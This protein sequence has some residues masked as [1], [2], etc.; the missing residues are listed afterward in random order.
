MNFSIREAASDLMHDYAT[1]IDQDRLE[2]WLDL[3]TEDCSYRV[4]PRENFDRDLPVSVMLCTNK[5]MIRD[6]VVALRKANEYNL[7]YDRHLVGSVRTA[8]LGED[9]WRLEASYALYQTTLGGETRLFSVGRYA[10]KVRLQG[11]RLM[12]CEKLVVID[13]FSVPTLLA[14]PI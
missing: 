1:L 10:D 9:I 4:V 14:T 12:F 13:T 6:R 3:F 5:N 11:G 7:H 8:P 2:E